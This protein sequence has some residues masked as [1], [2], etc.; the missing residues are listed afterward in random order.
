MIWMAIVAAEYNSTRRTALTA[1]M[2]DDRY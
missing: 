2:I 1:V